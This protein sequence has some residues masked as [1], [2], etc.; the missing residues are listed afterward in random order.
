MLKLICGEAGTGKSTLLRE[1]IKE[2]AVSGR[3]AVL[4]VPDQF[5]FETEK[6]IYRA[7]PKEYARNCRV[8]MFSR[9]AQRILRLHGETKE[10]ADDIAKRI[11]MKRALDESAADGALMYYRSQTRKQGFPVFALG[12]VSEMRNAGISPSELRG[13]LAEETELSGALSDKMNDISVIYSAYDRILTENFDDRLDDIRRAG[14]LVTETDVFDGYDVFFDEFDSFSGGQLG[15]I[16]ALLDKAASVTIALTC[17]Y[18]EC[19]ERKFEAVNRLIYRLSAAADGEKEVTA[20]KHRFRKPQSLEITEARDM[21]QECDW[22]AARIRSLTDEGVRY[23]NIAVL[24]P[25]SSYTGILGSAL[26][27]YGIPSFAD[28]PEPLITKSFVRFAIYTL[29]ALSFSTDDILRYVK[30]GFV[31]NPNGKV[32]SNIQSDSIEKLCRQYDLRRRDWLRPFPDGLDNTGELEKLRGSIIKPLSQLKKS[33]ENADG[34]EITRLLCDFLC[35]KTDICK[36]VYGKCILDRDKD[37]GLVVDRRRL[38]EYTEIWDDTVTVFESAYKAL[39]GYKMPI[40]EY[41]DILVDIFTSTTVAK[42]PQ[43]LD[44]VTVGDTERSRFTQADYVFICGY[45]QGMMP[46]PPRM[47]EVFTS[48]ESEQLTLLGIPVASD[49]LSRY[50]QELFTVYRCTGLPAKGLFVTYPLIGENGAFLEP[51]PSLAALRA[52]YGV[53]INGAD[54]YGA[55]YYCR[56]PGSAQRYLSHIY[57][58]RSRSGE[59]KALIRALDPVFTAM[60]R[61]ASGELPDKDR[62]T[63]TKER[64]S[65]LLVLDSW[66]PTAVTQINRCKF[67]FFCKY[68]LG[69]RDDGERQID[70]LLVGNVIHF[71][72]QRLLTGYA[73]KR[74]EFTS[75]TDQ[76]ISA[77]ISESI[78]IYEET[79]YYG[80]FGGAERFSY[81]LKRLGIYAVRAAVRI[82]DETALSGFYP[83][84]LE[85]KLSFRFGDVNISGVCDRIDALETDGKKYIRVVDYKRGTR[86]LSLDDIYKGENLQ[87]LLYLFGICENNTRVLPSSVMYLPVGRLSYES[88]DGSDIGDKALKSLRRYMKEHSPSGIILSDSPENGDITA[89]NDALSERFGKTRGGYISPTV[90]TPE[91]YGV[92]KSYCSS[93]I[94]SKSREA[95]A[96]MASACPSD[97]A[98]CEYCDYS[99]FCGRAQRSSF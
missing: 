84:A 65:K 24:V 77:H 7:V 87:M 80:G 68:G 91:I 46:P 33:L 6:L 17:D 94:S 71:C 89:L 60:L 39:K 29:K 37:G 98:V 83:E 99:L 28:I 12:M 27:K 38:D 26:K 63:V 34:A 43:T 85:K 64:S 11:A 53:Q 58:N 16:R 48:S 30:S 47:S 95:A 70:A 88:S 10:Y 3:K 73:G 96:G 20:L 55:D 13:R 93:Y 90:I 2:T 79:N 92:M 32:I 67:A 72:L 61:S 21:W 14:E 41:T 69:L 52:E 74:E 82:R 75:L 9:E 76:Q 66:S 56:T 54:N 36:T 42:P 25:D 86:D 57:R 35:N 81:L 78:K 49:R 31:R 1:R 8:T 18:P 51:A 23:R 62:H 4:F 45:V 97:P 50:S 40:E 59:R 15:F 5:S 22:I 19:K 44:A